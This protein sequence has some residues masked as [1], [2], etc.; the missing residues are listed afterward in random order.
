MNVLI[1]GSDGFIGKNLY[2]RLLSQKKINLYLITKKTS[3]KYFKE[4][5]YKSDV[6]FHFAGSNREY[7]KKKFT[8]NN[9]LLTKKICKILKKKSKKTK[10][11]YTSTS[12]IKKKN[13]YGISKKKAELELIKLDKKLV[14]LY[15]FRLPNIF[16]KW[17]K[18]NYNSVVATFCNN[19]INKKKLNIIQDKKIKFLY[20]DTL[21]DN[22]LKLLKNKKNTKIFHEI[23]NY[24]E[25]SVKKLAKK[26]ETFHEK[27]SQSEIP[28]IKNNFDKNLYSTYLSYVDQNK[29]YYKI[30]RNKDQRGQFVELFKNKSIGQVSFFSI[31]KNKIRGQH[32]HDSKI[33]KFF[34]I[35]GKAKFEFLNIIT[36]KKYSITIS[37]KNNKIIFTLPG[38]SH[39]IKNIG[40]EKALFV[41]WANEIFDI[42][43]PDTYFYKI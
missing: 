11:I 33:E 5:I 31:N 10:L 18:P 14:N 34:L 4:Y 37:E 13:Y 23:K 19:T 9:F 8:E 41:V 17:S 24:T 43:K 27:L 12:H 36:K 35:K 42:N 21:I 40:G 26:I 15:I 32:Y 25:I 22:F 16:G 1:I 30:I 38:W 39:K 6:I 3:Q 28:N 2:H 7:E 20:I 29:A